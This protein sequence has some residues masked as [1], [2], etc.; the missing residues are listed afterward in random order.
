MD[1]DQTIG[2]GIE[3]GQDIA[4][5]PRQ[6]ARPMPKSKDMLK[7]VL[8]LVAVLVV[9]GIGIMSTFPAKG[10]VGHSLVSN[11]PPPS[12]V[13]VYGSVGQPAGGMSISSVELIGTSGKTFPAT[14]SN[15][16]YQVLVQNGYNYS[17]VETWSG[18][19]PW[20]SG[21]LSTR[22][23]LSV[24]QGSGSQNLQYNIPAPTLP[25]AVVN[26]SGLVGL[27]QGS[28]LLGMN[29]TSTNGVL[30][31]ANV[32]GFADTYFALLPSQ[33]KYTARVKYK[34][35]T[36]TISSCAAG[37]QSMYNVSRLTMTLNIQCP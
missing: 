37:N 20:Q 25:Y 13:E 12:Q 27:P 17:L 28:T 18:P 9:V 7:P 10:S 35:F 34:S 26:V 29:F 1:G 14:L 4:A 3:A 16:Q 15:N 32:S 31:N 30:I 11:S 8:A 23:L 33:L 36:E 2:H 22:G 24:N 5:Q 19:Y 6:Q 21:T